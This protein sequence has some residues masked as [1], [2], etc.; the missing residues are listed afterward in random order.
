[1]TNRNELRR[2]AEVLV[3]P[4]WERGYPLPNKDTADKFRAVA[5]PE[6]VLGLLDEIE[7]LE[8]ECD[9][10]SARSEEERTNRGLAE[11]DF[12][13]AMELVRQHS[14]ERDQL[15]EEAQHALVI[16]GNVGREL[17]QT[18]HERDQ[19]R[20]EVDRQKAWAQQMALADVQ[21]EI[22]R[23]EAS[24]L[25]CVDT[26]AEWGVKAGALQAEVYTL[27]A[28][29]ERIATYCPEVT[30]GWAVRVREMARSALKAR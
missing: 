27:R 9:F 4:K 21:A 25:A 16:V 22:E 19:L 12:H 24:N 14:A 23:L 6:V 10:F 5:S 1:M 8:G 29:L 17:G 3:N 11:K 28:V 7:R 26:V 15:R 2:L 30:H 20:A 18:Q 13:D